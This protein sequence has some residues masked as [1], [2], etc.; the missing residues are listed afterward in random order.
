MYILKYDLVILAFYKQTCKT[1]DKVSIFNIYSHIY[2]LLRLRV[3]TLGHNSFLLIDKYW[4]NLNNFNMGW[5]FSDK[6][7][8]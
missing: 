4:K 1:L 5:M 7:T 6:T 8:I 2:T 3:S